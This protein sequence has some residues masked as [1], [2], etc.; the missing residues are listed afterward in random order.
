MQRVAFDETSLTAAAVDLV[1]G[2]LHEATEA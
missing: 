1:G 2:D